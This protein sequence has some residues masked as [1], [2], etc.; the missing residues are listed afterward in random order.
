MT[1]YLDIEI[2]YNLHQAIITRAKTKASIR[3]FALLHSAVERPKATYSGKDLYPTIF[4]KAASLIHSICL[5]H[6]FSDGNKRT[7]WAAT[8]L[9][10]WINGYHL[11]CKAH[12]AA[13][14]MV[15]LDNQKPDLVEIS[16]WLKS[17][18]KKL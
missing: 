12:E 15:Y 3:D 1:R 17:H 11:L 5:N 2:V 16:R 4:A 18:C 6:S 13:D 7:A 14:F 9:F 8:K 10:L